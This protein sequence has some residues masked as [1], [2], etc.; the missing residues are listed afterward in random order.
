MNIDLNSYNNYSPYSPSSAYSG[1]NSTNPTQNHSPKTAGLSDPQSAPGTTSIGNPDP[2]KTENST[3]P[4]QQASE[5]QTSGNEKFLTPEELRLVTE[6]KQTDTEVRNHE[7][8]HIAAGGSLI[9][10]RASFTYKR[11]PDGN[12]YAVGG[13]VGIDTSAIPGDPRATLEKMRQVKRSALAP[14]SP[15]SQDI[16]VASQATARAAKA[17]SELTTLMAKEQSSSN[18]SKAFGNLRKASDSYTKVNNLP[19]ES[20]ST[21]E[22][23]V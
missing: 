17:S 9:T 23:A 12:N 4:G 18:E 19:E 20:T 5:K 7:M 2:E 3:E 8:A 6:L 21:F 22:L 13:E 1:A 14:A 11:G 10:S 15:S 16:K